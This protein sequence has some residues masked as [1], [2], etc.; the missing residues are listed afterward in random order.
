MPAV[1]AA[2]AI[3]P[4]LLTS[5]ETGIE[6]V[7]EW[8]GD[9]SAT[10]FLFDVRSEEEFNARHLDGAV[11]APGGQL[12]QATDQWVA[13]R[14][15]RIVLCDD[16]GIRAANTAYWLRA[17]GHDAYVLEDDVSDSAITLPARKVAV[18]PVGATLAE[19]DAKEL[20][21]GG[22]RLIIDLRASADYRAAHIKDAVWSIRPKLADLTINGATEIV[23]VTPN[24]AF[25]ELAAMD[26][27]DAGASSIRVLTSGPDAWGQAGLSVVATPDL[28]S[29]AERLDFLFFVHDR[30]LGNAQ[31]SRD[32]LNWELG[33][34]GQ[35]KDWELDLFPTFADHAH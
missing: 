2:T 18:R 12:V 6:T 29:D 8:V 25:A 5:V 23:L 30:H 15:A 7:A 3:T 31:A 28:P 13:V 14:G 17:M 27:R 35:L 34:I 20:A 33:L 4:S 16:S 24:K 10:F 19:I 21:A 32:Y 11:F 22:D 1:A 26:L 9:D